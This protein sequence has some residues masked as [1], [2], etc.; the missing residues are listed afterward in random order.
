MD[1][2]ARDLARAVGKAVVARG[3]FFE[4]VSVMCYDEHGHAHFKCV[5]DRRGG[6]PSPLT[7]YVSS[8]E[9]KSVPD[10]ASILLDRIY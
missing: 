2:I 4:G 9:G 6:D 5:I 3:D 1:Q 10:L 7:F 8:D